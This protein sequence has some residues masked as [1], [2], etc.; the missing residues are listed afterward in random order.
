VAKQIRSEYLRK[1]KPKAFQETVYRVL[2]R[3]F[4]PLSLEGSITFGGRYNPP[5]QF[6]ALY[7]GFTPEICWSEIEKK[8][9]GPIDRSRFK[10]TAI[11]VR[12]QKVL[13]LTDSK[14]L[15]ALGIKP[16]LLIHPTDHVLTR[17]IAILAREAG[18]EAILAPSS[19]GPEHILAI[20]S[21]RLSSKSKVEIVKRKK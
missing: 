5:Y 10:M 1:V 8:I 18:F 21:D 6:P 14:V 9:E 15:S 3:R 13:D 2:V 4:S 11:R 16:E 17:Q 7:C 20:F 19:A 12:L